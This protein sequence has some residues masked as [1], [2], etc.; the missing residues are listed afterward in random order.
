[1]L[2]ECFPLDAIEH[3]RPANLFI[4]S[5][6]RIFKA[7]AAERPLLLCPFGLVLP[8]VVCRASCRCPDFLVPVS[9]CLLLALIFFLSPFLFLLSSGHRR[10]TTAQAL[11]S[12]LFC[13][14]LI[15][16]LSR[17]A[18]S[19][20]C[21]AR[22]GRRCPAPPPAGT[23]FPL[24]KRTRSSAAPSVHACTLFP[25]LCRCSVH[26]ATAAPAGAHVPLP[27]PAVAV[28]VQQRP[29]PTAPAD[30]RCPR[31]VSPGPRRAPLSSRSL[32]P[33]HAPPSFFLPNAREQQLPSF[34]SPTSFSCGVRRGSTPRL[35]RSPMPGSPV[36]TAAAEAPRRGA[37]PSPRRSSRA[38]L[39]RHRPP[40]SVPVC[41]LPGADETP[42]S[43]SCPAP[44]PCTPCR[45]G[46]AVL[47]HRRSRP[48][49]TAASRFPCLC[50]ALL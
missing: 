47:D 6:Q 49:S 19:F 25:R 7:L 22:C 37:V 12:P 3:L 10:S 16:T 11:P 50:D 15:D 18:L 35:E 48:A 32:P 21:F 9:V 33:E 44:S 34:H 23:S 17:S 5:S 30:A 43:R 2:I 31:R 36:S 1:M 8:T 40:S 29:C 42:P 45:L 28:P 26:A 46:R 38:V 20:P 24:R 41:L 14:L 13:L 4:T 27:W 39:S